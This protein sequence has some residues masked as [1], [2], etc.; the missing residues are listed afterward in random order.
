MKLLPIVEVSSQVRA[1][2]PLPWGVRDATGKLLL[3][4]GHLVTGDAM[5][6]A[7]LERGVYVDAEEVHAAAARVETARAENYFGRWQ[8]LHTRL[9]TLLRH[10]REPGFVGR[11]RECVPAI[12]ALQQRNPQLLI[13]L[14]LRHDHGHHSH[15]GAA[16]S[17]HVAAIASLLAQRLGWEAARHDR[18]VCAALTMNVSMIDLQGRLAGQAEPLNTQQREAVRRHPAESVRMLREAGVDDEAWLAAVQEH[19]EQPGGGGYPDA[20]LAPSEEAQLLALVDRYTAMHSAR[21]GREALPPQQV[22]RDIYTGSAGAPA[23]ALLI[24]E[25]GIYPPGSYVRLACGETAV[26]VSRGENA[27][28]PQVAS[29]L[30]RHGDPLSHPMRRDTGLPDYAIVDSVAARAVRVRVPAEAFFPHELTG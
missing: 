4:R 10:P 20:V 5:V 19:H 14:V 23:A 6:A 25:F 7:L 30:N 9:A 3:A 29:L 1:G 18:L 27:A 2:T 26:V 24:R 12:A 11:L 28:R 21:A 16:H 22:A 17:L 8:A 15:Y 13:F